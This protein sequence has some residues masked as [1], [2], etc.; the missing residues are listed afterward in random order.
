MSITSQPAMESPISV[1][2]DGVRRSVSAS[3][4]IETTW[5][6]LRSATES[7]DEQSVT[8]QSAPFS[9]GRRPG[10][11]LQLNHRTVSGHHADL[12]LDKGQLWVIDRQST[13]GTYVNVVVSPNQH[14]CAKKISFSS[15]TLPFASNE[16]DTLRAATLFKKMSAI[17]H[18]LW[19]SST[20]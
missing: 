1:H 5:M 13:N 16:V 7:N 20:A 14:H 19:S 11:S 15:P 10:S 4:A 9:V 3:E 17:K 18:S 2:V 6:L 12:E 8:V